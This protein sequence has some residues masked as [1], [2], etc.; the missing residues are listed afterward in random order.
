MDNG[1][2]IW[3]LI[4]CLVF[5]P[6]Y[7]GGIFSIHCWSADSLDRAALPFLFLAFANKAVRRSIETLFPFPTLL[8][9]RAIPRFEIRGNK[10]RMM[11]T[12]PATIALMAHK[13]R[14]HMK[15]IGFNR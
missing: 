12:N 8:G 13:I 2:M 5:F 14:A 10:E 1:F 7:T 3:I 4:W 11:V 15:S 6:A 9:L